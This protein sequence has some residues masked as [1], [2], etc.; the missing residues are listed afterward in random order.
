MNYVPNG[1]HPVSNL[2]RSVAALTF[3]ALSALA[4]VIS[5][6]QKATIQPTEIAN[7]KRVEAPRISPDGKFVA[8]TVDTPVASGKHRDAHIWISPTNRAGAARPFAYSGGAETSPDWSPDG[9]HLAF[10]SDR[11]NPLA[12]SDTS[13]Y[14]FSVAP[15]TNRKDI[16][17]KS[18]PKA[19][20]TDTESETKGMQLWWIALDGGEAEPLTN[21][22]G[23]IRAFKWSTDGKYIAFIRT[24]TDTPEERNRKKAKNDQTLIDRDYHYDRLW[25]YDLAKHQ[26]RLLTSADL[27]I[28]SID[29][30][31]DGSMIVARV[32]PTPRLDDYWRVSKAVLFN[33]TTGAI[34]RTVEEH[35]GY[36]GPSFSHDGRRI[37]YSRFTPHRITDIHI[38][39]NF[40]DG[41]EIKLEDKLNGTISQM[42]WKGA[43][44]GLLVSEYVHAH[45]EAVIVDTA[46]FTVTPLSEISVN[47]EE[48]HASND[49]RTVTFLGDTPSS[50]AEVYVW[51]DGHIQ[52]LTSTNPQIA[53][54][55]IGTQREISWQNPSDHR[56]IYGVLVLPPGYQPGV[57]Y[58]TIVHVHGGPEEA[59]T[60][61]FNGNWYNYATLL[62]SHGYVVLLPNPRGSDGQGPAFTEANFQAW[63]GEDFA[64]IMA[65]V[66]SLIAQGITDPDRM[67]IGGWSFGGFM[68]AWAVTHT[69]RF[70]AGMVGAGVTD[71]YSMA[72]TTDISPSFSQSYMGP[73]ATNAEIYDRN[74][75]VRYLDQC[76]TPVLVLHGEADPRV[77]I[78]QGQE[79]Y[80]GLRFL[81]KEAEMVTYP[82]EPHI[83]T[84]REHQI[85]SL[86]RVL[87]WYDTNLGPSVEK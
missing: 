76:H 42:V 5:S 56:A 59:W 9:M 32:S 65:G 63:G 30:S 81:G 87:A 1:S 6:A 71:L 23:N 75:P 26:A 66:D 12:E 18:E 79:F 55:S 13:P 19:E 51:Q 31:P 36:A 77:P 40:D 60:L 4:P 21:L 10:L 69:D 50:P 11:P 45:T 39:Q 64:D 8:Y 34:M 41:K 43:G 7:L 28:D 27:N 44:S 3:V 25:I 2:S 24:D 22:P 82:R 38:I 46:A 73:L 20:K 58:K 14:E 68:T 86:T 70:K 37:A 72:T 16:P 74:S 62:A 80:H 33:T 84:E 17:A 83:F 47:S 67:A 85:D 29:W 15:G 53:R 54:W 57:R 52:A 49:G 78:S 61:G 48:F 35:S